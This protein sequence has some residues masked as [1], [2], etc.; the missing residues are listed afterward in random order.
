MRIIYILPYDW[1]GMPHYTAELVNSVSE[2]EDVIVIG[3]TG[4]N[5]EYFSKNVTIFKLF[6]KLDFS[7]N[8]LHNIFY[9]SNFF[10]FCSYSNIKKI[11]EFQPDII[12]LTTPLFPPLA[13][14]IFL[15]KIDKKYPIVYTKHGVFSNSG[16]L[17]KIFEEY[18]LNI[19]EKI[20]RFKK[21]IVHTNHDKKDLK[22]IW[23]IQDQ[24]IIIIPHGAYSIF[25]NKIQMKNL[26]NSRTLLFFGNIRDYKGLQYLLESLPIIKKEIPDIKLIIAGEGD[27]RP[28][29]EI[30]IRLDPSLIEIHNYFIDDK[31]V[32]ELFQR[33]K[34]IVLP[35]TKMSGQSGIMN[36][37][38]A[39]KK[40]IIATDV[41]GISESIVNGI[42]GLLVPPK[43][44]QSLADATILLLKNEQLYQS[45]S[46]NI[47]K[48]R[49]LLSCTKIAKMHITTYKEIYEK[50]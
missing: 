35:Y 11:D 7:M 41:G 50:K 12:H 32:P 3:S 28:Y 39:F 4:I 42:T 36:I 40:P 23:R 22:S 46:D 25:E 33:A 26:T 16:Y 48:N 13:F 44:P 24:D 21:V 2:S 27:I 49:D 31:I 29:K 19:F 6:Y 1:G 17:K 38:F 34:I 14:F 10:A 15:Y 47:S 30:I 43:D 8:H 20:I 9:I 45:I 5:E 37:S 18:L